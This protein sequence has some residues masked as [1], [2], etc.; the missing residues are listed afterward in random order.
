MLKVRYTLNINIKLPLAS[1]L[2]TFISDLHLLLFP[3]NAVHIEVICIF[4]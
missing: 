1:K 4:N 2:I 3:E